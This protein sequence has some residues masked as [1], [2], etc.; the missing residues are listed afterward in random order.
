MVTI[1]SNEQKHV[2]VLIVNI[3]G[4][5]TKLLKLNMKYINTKKEKI[6]FI[7]VRIPYLFPRIDNLLIL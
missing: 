5:T 4:E 1:L 3:V 6:I 7:V 2:I